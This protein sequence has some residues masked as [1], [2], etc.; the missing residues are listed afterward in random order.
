MSSFTIR[1]NFTMHSHFVKKHETPL[2]GKHQN[3]S[4]KYNFLAH[5]FS[6]LTLQ[7]VTLC[8]LLIKQR[9]ISFLYHKNCIRY[10]IF[11]KALYLKC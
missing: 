8:P 10:S 1:N 3:Y 2:Y 7:Y 4:K 9:L 5:T 11:N 6:N